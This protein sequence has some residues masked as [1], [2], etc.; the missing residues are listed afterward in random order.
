MTLDTAELVAKQGGRAVEGRPPGGDEGA[1][2]EIIAARHAEPLAP[3]A[4]HFQRR[5]DDVELLVDQPRDQIIPLEG[6]EL[7]FRLDALAGLLCQFHLE[8]GRY[9][10]AVEIV[11]RRIRPLGG[12]RDLESGGRE[13]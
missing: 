1:G 8:A 9:A 5:H 3:L 11:E 2:R 12:D 4:S 13:R 6:G 7:A 10:L